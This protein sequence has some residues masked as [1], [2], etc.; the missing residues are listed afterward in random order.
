MIASP[1]SR[2]PTAVGSLDDGFISYVTSLPSLMT[3]ASASAEEQALLDRRVQAR[4]DK[5]FKASDDLRKEL[6]ARGILV[7]DTKQGQ[8][9]RRS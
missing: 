7:E 5:D 6:A 1:I 2:V 4:A 9:W 3:A 8:R